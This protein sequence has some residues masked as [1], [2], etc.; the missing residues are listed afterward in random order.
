MQK[1]F[2][3]IVLSVFSFGVSAQTVTIVG[4]EKTYSGQKLYL[5]TYNDYI[6][7]T[8]KH[9]DSCTV[10]PNGDFKFNFLINSPIFLFIDLDVFKGNMYAEPDKTYEIKLPSKQEKLPEDKLNPFFEPVEFKIPFLNTDTT[11]LNS[12][13]RYF[14]YLFYDF[15]DK[16]SMKIYTHVDAAFIHE[17]IQNID[18]N[19][20]HINH[21][22]FND[23][24]KYQ[25]AYL[26]YMF[27]KRDKNKIRAE[28]FN[29]SPILYDNDSYMNLFNLA[30]KSYLL[31]YAHTQEGKLVPKSINSH[32]SF[33]ALRNTVVYDSTITDPKIREFTI[34]KGIWDAFYQKEFPPDNLIILIDSAIVLSPYPKHVEIARTMKKEFMFMLEGYPPPAFELKNLHGTNI[35]LNS[36]KN[37]FVYLNFASTNSFTCLEHFS[38]LKVYDEKYR[39]YFKVVTIIVDG[40]FE[41]MKKLAAKEGYKWTILDA[42]SQSDIITTYKL[43]NYP[44]YYLID[45]EGN[46]SMSPALGPNEDFEFHLDKVLKAWQRKQQ[47]KSNNKNK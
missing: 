23:Y 41:Q 13:I 45:P 33:K 43:R 16:N 15:I 32:K 9:L 36:L 29:S 6:T 25:Y 35:S 47:V 27:Y 12:I 3:I 18:K 37:E 42:T 17:S 38:M 11:D 28:Y 19:F 4:N 22:F 26:K 40:D 7:K 21:Q 2:L 39:K 46:L 1:I 10:A 24:K 20:A 8:I 14:D 44:S 31:N 30:N 5:S 34:L